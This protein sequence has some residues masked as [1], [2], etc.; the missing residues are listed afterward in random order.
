[1]EKFLEQ[2]R[3]IESIKNLALLRFQLLLVEQYKILKNALLH[4]GRPL[5]KSV[6]SSKQGLDEFLKR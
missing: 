5:S 1:M 2:I 3:R 6:R 4:E